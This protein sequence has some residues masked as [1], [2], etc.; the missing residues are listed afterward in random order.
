MFFKILKIMKKS[1]LSISKVLLPLI[2]LSNM[3]FSQNAN[4]ISFEKKYEK[5][6]YKSAYKSN[7]VILQKEKTGLNY[8]YQAKAAEGCGKYAEMDSLLNL[9]ISYFKNNTNSD[10]YTQALKLTADTWYGYGAYQ[11]SSEYY[12]KAIENYSKLNGNDSIIKYDLKLLLAK[13]MLRQG[14]NNE[15][16]ALVNEQYNF[17]VSKIGKTN[18]NDEKPSEI[19]KKLPKS[20][21]KSNLRKLAQV[22]ALR[23]AAWLNR[24]EFRDLDSNWTKDYKWVKKNAGKSSIEARNLLVTQAKKYEIEKQKGKA[25]NYYLKAFHRSKAKFSEKTVL[26]ILEKVVYSYNAEND[27]HRA[28]KYVRKLE[29]ALSLQYGHKNPQYIRYPMLDVASAYQFSKFNKSFKNL[30]KVY[31]GKIAVPN[32]HPI[33]AKMLLYSYE[34]DT[35][36]SNYDQAQDTLKKLLEVKKYLYGEKSPEHHKTKLEWANFLAVYGNNFKKS[37][38]IEEESWDKIVAPQYSPQNLEYTQQLQQLAGL[39]DMIDKYDLAIEQLNLSAT[40]IEKYY[41]KENAAYASALQKLAEEYIKKG[42]FKKGEILIN[43]AVDLMKKVGNRENASNKAATYLTLSKLYTTIGNYEEAAKA[44]KIAKKTSKKAKDSGADEAA[45]KSTDEL[46][47]FYIK[48]GRYND[49]ENLLERTLFLKEKRFGKENKELITTLNQIA[50][51]NLIKGNYGEAEKAITRSTGLSSKIYGDS[52]IKYTEAIKMRED[53]YKKI[54]EFVKAEESAV[55]RLN[56]QRKNLGNNHIELA[57]TYSNIAML[58][59]FST[60]DVSKSINFVKNGIEIVKNNIGIENPQYAAQITNLATFYIETKEYDKADSLLNVADGIWKK[61]VGQ[62]NLNSADI[63]MLRGAIDY[64]QEKYNDAKDNFSVAKS[65]YATIFSKQHPGY[66]KASSRLAHTN[67]VQGD[68]SKSLV[69][70]DE[71]TKTYLNYTRKYFPSLSF[72]E[73]SKYWN[74]IKDD[75]EFYN[76]LVLKLKDKKPELIGKMYDMTMATKAI[77]LSSSI[78]VRERIMNSKDDKLIMRYNEWIG[79]KEFL[80]T[81]ISLSNESLKEMGVN[82]AQ[83]EK[84]ITIAEKDLSE[85]SEIFASNNDKKFFHWTDV[86]SKL[87]EN[88]YA[89]EIL[90]FR[91][92]TST[93]TDEPIY[94]ALIINKLTSKKPEMVVMSNG[95]ELETKFLK[96]YRNS[97]K[98]HVEDSYS[99]ENYWAPIKQKIND[100]SVIYMS[101]EGVYNQINVEAMMSENNSFSIDK[102]DFTFVSNTKDLIINSEKERRPNGQKAVLVGNPTFYASASNIEKDKNA[103]AMRGLDRSANISFKKPVKKSDLIAKDLQRDFSSNSEISQ[104]PGTEEEVNNLEGYLLTKNWDVRKYMENKAD[105]DT[106][107][108]IRQP[109]VFHI[110]THGFFKE[111]VNEDEVSGLTASEAEFTQNPLLRSGLLLK[112]AGDVLKSNSILDINSEKGVLTAYEAMNMN[113][114]NTELVVLSACETG[115]GQVQV[116]EGVFGLQ[117]SFLVAGASTVIMSLFKVNDEVT[118]KLMTRFYELWLKTGDK[119]KS[120]ADAKRE[121]KKLYPEPIYWGSF[122]MSGI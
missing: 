16:L 121:I 42:D 32:N 38:E 79:K 41:G 99:Y 24:G 112:G 65:L 78:K 51:L 122:V 1:K 6:T 45:S 88:E 35:K 19:F 81:V 37:Q 97:T 72:S 64:K 10:D 44:L 120:F 21:R 117:R 18:I 113:L 108:A 105:E 54:G 87:K 28:R 27:K 43:E 52:S 62:K 75:F 70:M 34:L 15:A 14:F 71:I 5:G 63:A 74:L 103:I 30:T 91:N 94:A 76:S 77:M 17:R 114:D 101:A 80:S 100:G 49:A 9:G 116:G 22:I 83:L 92:F 40:T 8:I 67:F 47:D 115:L 56:I 93:F 73:K 50:A 118:Q 111:D 33:Q 110:A 119:R 90:R 23:D 25:T 13:S 57:S 36:N 86:K 46:V 58:K 61:I 4:Q 59:F 69:I 60:K 107:K 96:Y 7:S 20:E 66:V 48:N 11:K 102:N 2:F 109:K 85:S 3:L 98:N 31:K 12:Q 53:L 104:L 84:E 68:Y 95:K 106:V 39:Y 29:S 55:Q 26:E 89:V 82:V